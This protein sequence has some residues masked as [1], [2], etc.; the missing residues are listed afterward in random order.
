MGIRLWRLVFILGSVAFVAP[1]SEAQ[2]NADRIS[3]I[4]TSLNNAKQAYDQLPDQVKKVA[5]TQRR[6]ARLSEAVNRMAPRL[7]KMSPGQPWSDNRVNEAPDVNG[8]VR[9]NNPARDFRFSNFVGY[10]QDES[11]IARCGNNVVVAFNDTGSIVETLANGTAGISFSGVAASRDGGATFRD[12][13]AVPPG[14]N[15][16]SIFNADVLLG[17]P[18]VACSDSNNFYMVQ[19]YFPA[20]GDLGGAIA[21]SR[22]HDGGQTWSDPATA[23]A[24]PSDADA[25][26]FGPA[27]AVDPTNPNR[28]YVAY[29]HD[30]TLD[31]IC[32][33]VSTVEVVASQDSGQTFGA[34]VILDRQ[35]WFDLFLLDIGPRLA[36]S[37][38]GKVYAA[39][40]NDFVIPGA[41]PLLT[42]TIQVAS[43][44][45][46]SAPAA[47]VVVATIAC[48]GFGPFCSSP[49]TGGSEILANGFGDTTDM[50]GGFANIRGFDLAVDTSGGPSNGAV[51][52][53]WD[54]ALGNVM[55]PEFFDI[56]FDHFGFYA[57]TDI[58]ISR[59]ADGQNFSPPQQLNSD[60]QPL[61]GSRGHD[62]FRP[63]LAVDKTGRVAG[64][65]YDR[66]NDPQNF[67]FERFCAESA[68]A[69]ATWREFRVNGSLSTPSRGQD[70]VLHIDD[71]GLYD[72]LT[73][74]FT[75]HNQGF[76]GSFQWMSSGMNPDLKAVQF[77]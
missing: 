1:H 3:Q 66:R 27:V 4:Q 56:S 64:C 49:V 63:A 15:G 24:A 39:W 32:G 69:G 22:S 53:A 45:P 38:S 19:N 7:A 9:V 68:D 51:Y 8:L 72:G 10:T 75:G 23:V 6:L 33:I 43:F 16:T 35:C 5:Q 55:A 11:A 28:I 76:I 61:D 37:S 74:D 77:Q 25:F 14:G 54:A 44:T 29:V 26:A 71:M 67:Q 18:S 30:F 62:H 70:L 42:Q 17:A 60:L 52:V 40:F 46:G 57:F 47:P 20:S 73:S 31:P 21:I 34:P 41:F 50:Q 48:T 2:T 36:V 12:L 13:G 65:W 59:S 58:F